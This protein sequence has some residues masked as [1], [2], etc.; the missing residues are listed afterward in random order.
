[1]VSAPVA[2]EVIMASTRPVLKAVGMSG[3]STWVGTAPTSWAK[4]SLAVL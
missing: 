3:T 2:G 4:R 1:M